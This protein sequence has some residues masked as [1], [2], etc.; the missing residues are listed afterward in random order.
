MEVRVCTN[1]IAAMV[2]DVVAIVVGREKDVVLVVTVPKD[3]VVVVDQMCRQY[4]V[5]FS[6]NLMVYIFAIW[7]MLL[8]RRGE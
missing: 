3:V 8:L 7:S 6:S 5:S 4:K 1:V 2:Q